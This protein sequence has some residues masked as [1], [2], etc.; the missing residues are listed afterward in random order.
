MGGLASPSELMAAARRARHDAR[1]NARASVGTTPIDLDEISARLGGAIFELN[2]SLLGR[3]LR[4]G[5][6]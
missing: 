1:L 2:S 5:R 4:G 6:E 3:A